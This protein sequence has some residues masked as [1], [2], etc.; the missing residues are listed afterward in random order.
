MK[1]STIREHKQED[2][3]GAR[4]APL[5]FGGKAGMAHNVLPLYDAPCPE[6]LA[7]HLRFSANDVTEGGVPEGPQGAKRPE[8]KAAV[9]RSWRGPH[10][11]EALQGA[12]L[13]RTK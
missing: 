2:H 10:Q 7:R 1:D 6:G 8:R 9:M 13:Q 11:G 3:G 5:A 12:N 4:T